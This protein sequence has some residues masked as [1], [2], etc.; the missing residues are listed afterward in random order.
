MFNLKLFI[1]A[2]RALVLL[3]FMFGVSSIVTGIAGMGGNLEFAEGIILE[4]KVLF[5][6]INFGIYTIAFSII[7]GL[8]T[9]YIHHQTSQSNITK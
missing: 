2:S 8:I 3:A 5:N 7:L 9:E 6:M 4:G 1:Y